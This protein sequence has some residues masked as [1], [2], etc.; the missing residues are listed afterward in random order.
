MSEINLDDD[1]DDNDDS[2]YHKN[3]YPYIQSEVSEDK[4]NTREPHAS[5]VRW[6]C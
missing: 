4:K 3:T 5:T 1:D 6:H 2:S